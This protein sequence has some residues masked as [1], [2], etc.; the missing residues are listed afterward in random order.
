MKKLF[1]I[2]LFSALF[3]TSCYKD[4][5][6]YDYN[7]IPRIEM[8]GIEPE[9]TVYAQLDTLHINPQFAEKA[10]CSCLW[11]L[12]LAGSPKANVDT[13]STEPELHYRVTEKAG[14]YTLALTVENEN[15]GDRQVFQ[16]TVTVHT[17]YSTGC[18]VLKEI[19]G[20]TD[21]DLITERHQ[22]MENVLEGNRSRLAG[23][24]RA[25]TICPDINYI[26]AGGKPQERVKT[27][28]ICSEQDVRMMLL[29]NM[30]PIYDIHSMFYE[31]QPDEAPQNMQFFSNCLIY[32][33]NNG[34]YYMTL[35]IMTA[36][37]KF[38]LPLEV[39]NASGQEAKGCS[40]ARHVISGSLYN[41][42]YD[43]SNAR[44]LLVSNGFLYRFSDRDIWGR[45]ALSPN[46]MNC[47]LVYMCKTQSN[48]YALMFDKNKQRHVI[49]KLETQAYDRWGTE[50]FSPLL[51]CKELKDNSRLAQGETFGNNLQT[52]YIY[53]S[54]GNTLHLFDC[55]SMQEE[56]DILHGLEGDITLIKHIQGTDKNERRYEYLVIGITSDGQYELYFHEMIAGKPD[57]SKTPKV[58]KG[59]GIP[60][61]ICII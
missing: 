20:Q 53:F 46:N 48:G 60:T 3:I 56:Q 19:D 25:I 57:L 27:L 6:N 5:G 39:A 4:K 61:D 22:L 35:P 33:S 26:D 49:Y 38:G 29:E 47:D 12:F 14:T 59:T 55:I 45:P 37:H 9:Y 8:S 54:T 36:Q 16:S 34:C 32:F 43:S 17:E 13:L 41:I 15:T 40:C 42:F 1:Y 10:N 28:W 31:E 2:L 24:P 30:N 50:Y 23:K 52:P 44:F 21:I 58:I 7:P 11:T 18:Y 51:E